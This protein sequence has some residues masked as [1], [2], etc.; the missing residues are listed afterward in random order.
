VASASDNF[1]RAD[2]GIG[3]NW[4]QDSG[5][6]VVRTNRAG[7]DTS[8]GSYRKARY[9]ATAPATANHYSE[10]VVRATS[11]T[12]AGAIVRATV[13]AAVTYYTQMGFGDDA[14][15]LL[16]ITAGAETILDT[17]SAMSAGV[18]YTVRCTAE[19]TAISGT[20]GGAADTSATDATLTALGWGLG[21][22]GGSST[23]IQLSMNDWAAAD[24]A[25]ATSDALFRPRIAGALLAR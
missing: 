1:D 3:A 5:A 7:Q 22:F 13:G 14:F 9:T 12:A 2:G 8:G 20:V 17:G 21:T 4:T 10:A 25:A 15:Y 24:T 23:G 11:T 18:D 6:W 16:E 19:G